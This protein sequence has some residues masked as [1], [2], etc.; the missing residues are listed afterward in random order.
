MKDL[1]E[2]AAQLPG[3]VDMG[4]ATTFSAEYCSQKRNECFR[5]IQKG[6]LEMDGV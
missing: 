2:A 5:L 4:A 3:A 1:A 6:L